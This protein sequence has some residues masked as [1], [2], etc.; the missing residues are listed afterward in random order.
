MV[1][2]ISFAKCFNDHEIIN[3]VLHKDKT[4]GAVRKVNKTEATNLQQD[5][6]KLISK[7]V[8]L[9]LYVCH[10]IFVLFYLSV[11]CLRVNQIPVG[12]SLVFLALDHTW[13]HMVL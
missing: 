1:G 8:L 12:F 5:N 10:I 7:H 11:R 2:V 6:D 3:C 13:N 9:P 4:N